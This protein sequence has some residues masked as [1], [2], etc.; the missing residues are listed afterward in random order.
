MHKEKNK[1]I[2][3]RWSAS[4]AILA[5]ANLPA[6]LLIAALGAA[7]ALLLNQ[8]VLLA[9]VNDSVNAVADLS[10][11]LFEVSY[12]EMVIIKNIDVF[13]LCE[14]HML[15]FFGK[16]HIAY[17]PDKKIVGLSKI[18]RV[19]EAFAR[20]LQ[21]QER[22]TVQIAECLHRN[23]EADG[24]EIRLSVYVAEAHEEHLTAEDMEARLP[25]L[26]RR[27]SR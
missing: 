8:A 17:I 2:T 6:A 7:G 3:R 12:D 4:H 24:S 11:A 9:G 27:L 22:M 1:N 20:R 26:L 18:A 14:H 15:P 5:P 23:L 16:A 10:E 25:E 19:V 21:V 13:S